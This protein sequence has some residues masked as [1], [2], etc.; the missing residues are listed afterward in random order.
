MRALHLRAAKLEA[1]RASIQE[2][3]DSGPGVPAE[4]VFADPR[5][6]VRQV[7]GR[8]RRAANGCCTARAIPAVRTSGCDRRAAPTGVS[9][10]PPLACSR[11]AHRPTGWP[12]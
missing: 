5:A 9:P 11:T 2:G 4:A 8:I 7:A 6:R 10:P 3:A 12:P 1:L